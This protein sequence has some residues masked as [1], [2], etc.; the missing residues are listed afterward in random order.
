MCVPAAREGCQAASL[1]PGPQ[2]APLLQPWVPAGTSGL[3]EDCGL[4]LCA[5][6]GE[7]V[8]PEPPQVH[9]PDFCPRSPALPAPRSGAHCPEAICGER[10]CLRWFPE[11]GRGFAAAAACVCLLASPQAPGCWWG[12]HR[13]RQ[14]AHPDPAET[15]QPAS[16]HLLNYPADPRPGRSP[17]RIQRLVCSSVEPFSSCLSLQKVP[18]Q[19]GPLL[20][21]NAFISVLLVGRQWALPV[22]LSLGRAGPQE[23]PAGR[24]SEGGRSGRAG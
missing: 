23:P 22:A 12:R 18:P 2:A 15:G 14:R 8:G 1:G 5:A 3:Q 19:A 17:G 9:R 20:P 24:V 21:G 6:G 11:L 4:G 10:R 13:V 16:T 7:G